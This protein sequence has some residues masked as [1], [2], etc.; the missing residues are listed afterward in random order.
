M[1]KYKFKFRKD[2]NFIKLFKLEAEKTE[3]GHIKLNDLAKEIKVGGFKVGNLFAS[4]W[5]GVL[6]FGMQSYFLR[7]NLQKSTQF[8]SD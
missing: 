8:I 7:Q 2:P 4:F 1:V 6:L 3:D 5:F